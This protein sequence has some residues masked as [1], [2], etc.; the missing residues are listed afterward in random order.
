[1]KNFKSD[2]SKRLKKV[3]SLIISWDL[4]Q[5]DKHDATVVVGKYNQKGGIDVVNV[6]VKGDAFD[7]L[8]GLMDTLKFS[9][10][11]LT[12]PIHGGEKH[13]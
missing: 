12:T 11:G 13:G 9:V 7:D 10:D 4:N 1:M 8:R 3:D 5:T 2:P 6:S